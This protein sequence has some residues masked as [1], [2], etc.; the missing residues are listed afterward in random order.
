MDCSRIGCFVRG[1][2]LRWGMFGLVLALLI[3]CGT[4]PSTPAVAAPGQRA[5][6]WVEPYA[7][8]LRRT[9]APANLLALRERGARFVVRS[10]TP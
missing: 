10:A 3:G 5:A 9:S 8:Q 7:F 2:K 6:Q 4:A 1:A